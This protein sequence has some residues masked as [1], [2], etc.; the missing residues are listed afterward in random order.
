MGICS[1]YLGTKRTSKLESREDGSAVW[2]KAGEMSK[3]QN[4]QGGVR[5]W[6]VFCC[7]AENELQ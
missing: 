1:E 2:K 4:S 5:V 3:G 7:F 6:I